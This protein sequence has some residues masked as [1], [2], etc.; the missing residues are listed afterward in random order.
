MTRIL[1]PMEYQLKETDLKM[2]TT[3]DCYHKEP[4]KSWPW[5]ING[6]EREKRTNIP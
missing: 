5:D 3:Q 1:G 2:A 4:F 6:R